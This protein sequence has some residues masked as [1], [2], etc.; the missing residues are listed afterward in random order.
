V[1]E[2]KT[3]QWKLTAE[4]LVLPSQVSS[5]QEKLKTLDTLPSPLNKVTDTLNKFSNIMQNALQKTE[6]KSVP[7]VGQADV[8]VEFKAPNTSSNAEKMVSQGKNPEAKSGLRRKQS[9]KHTFES[10]TKAS[11][12]KTGH[13]DKENQSSSALDNNQSQPSASTPV[14]AE[15]HKKAQQAG[16][17]TSLRATSEQGADPQIS[18]G[19]GALADSTAEVDPGISAPLDSIPQKQDKTKSAGDGLKT[20][21]TNS[22]TNEESRSNEISKTMKLE[23]LSNLIQD[24]RSDFID[25]DSLENEPI[26]VTDE[27]EEEEAERY[28]D[29]H[30]TS[31]NEPEDTS[32]EQ[33]KEKA[34]AEAEVAFLKAQPF[35]LPTE[36]KE[37]PSKITELSGEDKVLKKHIQ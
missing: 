12:S 3:L 27:S 16:D 13:L 8:H 14:V 33:Q 25:T 30:A 28:K 6:D 10:K 24:V 17:P 31:H 35:Y 9:S 19:R 37:L 1:A 26:I 34:K 21:H 32:L 11:K 29:T 36:L 20:A 2:L 22:C 4:F 23:D 18:S 5:V 7:S 15:M